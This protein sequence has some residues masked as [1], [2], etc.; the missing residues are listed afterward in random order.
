MQSLQPDDRTIALSGA[1]DP[2]HPGHLRMIHAARN[3]GRVLII[4]NSDE[5]VR[6][7]RG[8]V[9][10]P[11]ADRRDI[12][13]AVH[14]VDRVEEVDDADDTVCEALRRLRPHVFGNGGLRTSRNTPE[15]LLCNEL[16][17]VGVWGIGGGEH[18]RYSNEILERVYE[19]SRP[20]GGK[21]R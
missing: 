12:L 21:K 11:W 8:V 19:A 3:F 7:N 16:G 2:L 4:L 6:R 14:G 13:L 18:D 17:I 1:F 20:A 5:W 15:R 10:M 9:I